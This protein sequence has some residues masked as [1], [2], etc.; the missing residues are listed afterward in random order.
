MTSN[1]TDMSGN[2]IQP[3]SQSFDMYKVRFFDFQDDGDEFI[4][5]VYIKAA[6]ILTPTY[7]GFS[8]DPSSIELLIPFERLLTVHKEEEAHPNDQTVQ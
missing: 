5:T 1:I 8:V 4:H 6:P 7:V 3:D 2:P